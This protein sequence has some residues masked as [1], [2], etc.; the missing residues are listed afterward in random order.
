MALVQVPGRLGHR[1]KMP[2]LLPWEHAHHVLVRARGRLTLS[3]DLQ[4][5]LDTEY[6][7][8][9]FLILFLKMFK[10]F[11][12]FGRAGLGSCTKQV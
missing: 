10:L 11:I 1:E 3:C 9:D 6:R 2:F 5:S 8:V 12:Y 7:V 4:W